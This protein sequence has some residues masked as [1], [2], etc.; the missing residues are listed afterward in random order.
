MVATRN[1]N[2]DVAVNEGVR[3]WVAEHFIKIHGENVTW[4]VYEEAILKRFDSINEDPMA[5]LKNLSTPL[6]H[7][8]KS[9]NGWYA[10][11]N[12]V[13][14]SRTTSSTIVLPAPNTKYVSKHSANTLPAPR[15]QIIHKQFAKNR[16]KNLCFYRDKKYMH[17]HKCEGQMFTLEIKGVKEG[18]L[19]RC[20]EEGDDETKMFEYVLTKEVP[21]FTPHISLNVV[22]GVPTHNT[23]RVKGHALKNC[24]TY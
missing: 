5:E 6:L 23:M 9:S 15:K 2:L 12:V 20:L 1:D 8:H 17:G 24:S 19:E 21:Q 3:Q 16:A 14:P 10:N 7:D 11:N 22:S 18:E 4:V 13:Y